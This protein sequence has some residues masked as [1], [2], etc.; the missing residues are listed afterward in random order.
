MLYVLYLTVCVPDVRVN[1]ELFWI[2]SRKLPGG[3]MTRIA[4]AAA[5]A[6]ACRIFGAVMCFDSLHVPAGKGPTMH[7]SFEL[8]RGLGRR[9]MS[10]L[11][12]GVLLL[13]IALAAPAAFAAGGGGGGGGGGAGGGG[14]GAG[15]GGAGAGGGG[16]GAGGGG[17]GG[18]YHP[19]SV[20]QDD[21]T[22]CY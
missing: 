12:C 18:Y 7:A 20:N 17:G 13:G 2:A 8:Y 9:L 15:G 4:F 1:P 14:A 3:M 21:L 6:K 10:A 5:G 16:A 19:R 22:T 11:S